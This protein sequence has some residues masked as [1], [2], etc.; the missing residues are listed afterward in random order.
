MDRIAMETEHIAI[1]DDDASLRRA[2]ARMVRARS[3]QVQ[4]YSSGR[5]FLDSLSTATPECL[6]LDLLMGS[7]MSNPPQREAKDGTF[8]L[9]RAVGP[10]TAA[11]RLNDCARERQSYPH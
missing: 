4:T 1:V 6:I 3:F 2:M 10:Q 11:M 7:G 8:L 9:G 5:E